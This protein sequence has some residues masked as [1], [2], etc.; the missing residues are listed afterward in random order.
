MTTLYASVIRLYALHPGMLENDPGRWA[1]AAF[2]DLVRQVDPQLS[3]ALH[4]ANMRKPFTIGAMEGLPPTHNGPVTVSSGQM[5]WLRVTTFS[6][7]LFQTFTQAFLTGSVRPNLQIGPVAFG[8]QGVLTTPGSHPWA[9]FAEAGALMQAVNPEV[10][11]T[12]EFNSPTA[13]HLSHALGSPSEYSLF[14]LPALVFGSLA[15]KWRQFVQ[16][17]LEVAYVEDVASGALISSYTLRTRSLRWAG[18]VQKGFTGRCA[19]D[20]S[21]LPADERCLLVGLADFAFYAGVGG[22]TTQGMGQ[23]RRL[24]TRQGVDE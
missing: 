2:Y 17:D 10:R 3:A 19:Y 11:L 7:E 24:A 23:A 13:F 15:S 1:N 6:Q 4:A 8:V 16:P 5:A 18:R 14:P 22:K 12:L 9:G 21:R 20:L